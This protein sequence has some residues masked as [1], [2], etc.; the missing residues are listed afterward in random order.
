MH[1]D[2]LDK[3]SDLDSSIHRLDPRI[4]LLCAVALLVAIVATSPRQ[5]AE[6][7]LFALLLALLIVIS[8]VPVLHIV[9]KSLI[10]FPFILL[11]A[12]FLPFMKGGTTIWEGRFVVPLRL[13]REGITMFVNVVCKAYLALATMILLSATT[14]FVQILHAMQALRVPRLVIMILSFMY[15]YIFL[16]IDEA[17]RMLTAHEARRFGLRGWRSLT[18]FGQLVGILFLRTYERGERV[19]HAMTSR[20]FDG[21]VRVFNPPRLTAADVLLTA[22]FLTLLAIIKVLG[23]FMYA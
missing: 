12:I 5:P 3:Y 17:E 23:V 6:F 22:L 16:L 19:Y 1:H 11:V 2:F 14:P 15:R 7:I 4:K 10:L 9:K 8:R 20:G 18:S 13:T 21:T